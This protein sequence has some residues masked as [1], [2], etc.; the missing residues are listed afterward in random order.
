M[1]DLG[2][3]MK[4]LTEL[5]RAFCMEYAASPTGN[6]SEAARRAGYSSTNMAGAAHNLIHNPKIQA[7]IKEL[8]VGGFAA[9]LPKVAETL[10]DIAFN[11]QHRD[12]VKAIGMVLQRGGL[13]EI[14][15]RTLNVNVT[16]SNAEK[17]AEIRQLA[18]EMEM[19]AEKLLGNVTDAEFEELP[20]L[21]KP[22]PALISAENPEKPDPG[23]E[24]IDYVPGPGAWF[25]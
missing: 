18:E 11:P 3:A 6:A 24:F 23:G 15:E 25:L 20:A 22:E 12:Q 9:E 4:A 17:I 8:V 7:G 2:P 10:K 21:P 13:P 19:D 16:I 14:S 1:D 5:Q